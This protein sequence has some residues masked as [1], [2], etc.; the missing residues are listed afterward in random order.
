MLQY[1]TIQMWVTIFKNK[2]K[3]PSDLHVGVHA[4]WESNPQ[5]SNKS[6]AR[7]H[8]TINMFGI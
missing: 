3:I 8:T 2:D 1:T 7:T 5:Q 6:T 4:N